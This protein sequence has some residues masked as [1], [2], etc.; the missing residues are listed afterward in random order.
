MR[1]NRRQAS[2]DPASRGYKTAEA[3][4]AKLAVTGG[5]P[6]YCKWGARVLYD[7]ADLLA[8]ADGRLGP[9]HVTTAGPLSNGRDGVIRG[10]R[11]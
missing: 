2:L 5:G 11:R 8:W 6:V 7:D 9:K 4:L 3:T 1:L 10:T